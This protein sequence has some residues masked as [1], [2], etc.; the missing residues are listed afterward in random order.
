MEQ[1]AA[2]L[3]AA[4]GARNCVAA[5]SSLLASLSAICIKAKK[6]SGHHFLND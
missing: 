5:S 2:E 3:Y 1:V 6:I 4:A